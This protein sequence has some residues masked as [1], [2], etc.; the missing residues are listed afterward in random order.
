MSRGDGQRTIMAVGSGTTAHG[1]GR[2]TDTSEPPG[3]GGI[4]PLSCYSNLIGVSAG[5]RFRTTPLT[6]ILI[7]IT[8]TGDNRE[9]ATFVQ[10]RVLLR[11]IGRSS[12][13]REGTGNAI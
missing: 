4:R 12:Q 6:S 2:L 3:V 11:G 1:F 7:G 5:T 10:G 8:I 13:V 9:T